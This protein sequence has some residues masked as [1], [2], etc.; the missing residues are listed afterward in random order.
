[1]ATGTITALNGTIEIP[2]NEDVTNLA[3]QVRGTFAG[4]NCAF[5]GQVEEGG[6]WFPTDAVRSTGNVVETTS[7]VLGASPAYS[8]DISVGGYKRLRVRN[9]AYTSGS[10]SWDYRAYKGGPECAPVASGAVAINAALPAGAAKVG[11][12]GAQVTANATGAGVI[13]KVLSAASTNATNVKASAGRLYGVHLGNTSAAWKYLKLHN[14]AA[15]PT[16][17]AGVV[18]IIAIPPGGQVSV[19]F[20][21]GI[22]FATGIGYT[23]TNLSPDADVTAVAAGDVVGTLVFA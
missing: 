13:A 20:D 12:V 15:A 22:G 3:L 6:T 11:D 10:Q 1:M 17:G 4:H 9:T 18:A 21:V 2:I 8:W 5:E 7:G 23:I 14:T 19:G 16:P